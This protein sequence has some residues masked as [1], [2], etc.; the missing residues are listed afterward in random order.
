MTGLHGAAHPDAAAGEG[1]FPGFSPADY[2]DQYFTRFA[3][4]LE[5]DRELRALLRFFARVYPTL[6]PDAVT[7]E[8]GGGPTFY[9]LVTAAGHVREIHFADPVAANR[10]AV[11]AWLGDEPGAFDWRPWV[12]LALAEEGL[13]AGAEDVARRAARIRSV[14]TRVTTGDVFADPPVPAS[15]L[16]DA[17]SM[18]FV[19]ESV[20]DDVQRWQNGLRNAAQLLR[21]GGLLVVAALLGAEYWQCRDVRFPAL[22]LTADSLR[23]GVAGVADIVDFETITAAA[24]RPLDPGYAGYSGMGFVAA[25][26]PGA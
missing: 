19:V 7:L 3:A 22:S 21:P 6:P 13:S 18:S 4:D 14:V 23:A 8:L 12:R 9:Q 16:Y 24:P 17:V 10:D 5:G 2:L 11:R 15:G 1:A 20:T 25:R 26:R